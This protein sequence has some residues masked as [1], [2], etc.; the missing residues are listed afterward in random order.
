MVFFLALLPAGGPS[1]LDLSEGASAQAA[2]T[3]PDAPLTN[4]RG[5]Q[6]QRGELRKS[7][8]PVPQRRTSV[9]SHGSSQE[10]L[11]QQGGCPL[12]PRLP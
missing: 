4:P 11:R 9:V 3:V 8:W 12:D 6:S 1:R 7:S 10:C 5:L 2:D